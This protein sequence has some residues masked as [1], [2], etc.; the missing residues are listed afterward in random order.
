MES[1][2][3]GKKVNIQNGRYRG[4]GQQYCEICKHGT[5]MTQLFRGLWLCM[6]CYKKKAKIRDKKYYKKLME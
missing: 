4:R 5:M 2:K 1:F 3:K 6:T